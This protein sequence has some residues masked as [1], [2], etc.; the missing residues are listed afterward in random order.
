MGKGSKGGPT[1]NDQRS[2][3]MNSQDVV[4]KM[5]IDHRAGQLDPRNPDFSKARAPPDQTT[6]STQ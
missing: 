1:P 4:G 3:A 6:E 5:A 2:R